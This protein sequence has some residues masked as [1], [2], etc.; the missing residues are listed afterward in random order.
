MDI[1]EIW[2]DELEQESRIEVMAGAGIVGLG[3]FAAAFALLRRRR[4]FFAWAIPGALLS[5]GVVMLANVALDTRREQIA[6]TEA[7]IEQRVSVL[8]PIARALVLKNVSQSQLRAVI[9]GRD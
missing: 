9:P 8:D 6:E 2:R 3:V 1:V 7:D 5:A 4:G